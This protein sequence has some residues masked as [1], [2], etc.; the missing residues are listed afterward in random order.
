MARTRDLSW[1]QFV[2]A[3]KREGFSPCF[4]GL[5]DDRSRSGKWRVVYG[6][7]TKGRGD[8]LTIDRRASLARAIRERQKAD[9]EGRDRDEP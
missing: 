1:P 5:A 6:Y 3:A 8:G 9:T 7:V 2:R 4:V